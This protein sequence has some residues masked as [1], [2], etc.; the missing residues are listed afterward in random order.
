MD[1]D[2]PRT[3][4]EAYLAYLAGETIDNEDTL[5]APRDLTEAW[6]AFWAGLIDTAPSE[7]LDREQAY[8]AYITNESDDMPVAPLTR[9]E[10]YLAYIADSENNEQ[11]QDPRD[12]EEYFLSLISPVGGEEEI[13]EA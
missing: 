6:L 5:K 8:I 10:G 13:I 2:A 3:R 11:P 4:K 12:R 7:I 1:S 9:V